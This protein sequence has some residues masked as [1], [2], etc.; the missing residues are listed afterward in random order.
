MTI[1]YELI[2]GITIVVLIFRAFKLTQWYRSNRP[3]RKP[4]G[5]IYYFSDIGQVLPCVKIGRTNNPSNRLAAHRTGAPL[6]IFIW[7]ILPVRNDRVA[8]T[9]FHNRYWRINREW[10]LLSPGLLFDIIVLHIIKRVLS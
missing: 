6:G 3:H 7:I 8:E 9:F 4:R 2:A 5:Y 1:S 10:F